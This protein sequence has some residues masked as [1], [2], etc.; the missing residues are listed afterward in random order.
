MPRPRWDRYTHCC[1]L[2]MFCWARILAALVWGPGGGCMWCRHP[3][4]YSH[5]TGGT[6]PRPH[7]YRSPAV[8]TICTLPPPHHW[9]ATGGGG[10]EWR[11]LIT[12]LQ[13]LHLPYL[14]STSTISTIYVYTPAQCRPPLLCTAFYA[15]NILALLN[16]FLECFDDLIPPEIVLELRIEIFSRAEQVSLGSVCWW[17]H[18]VW[19]VVRWPGQNIQYPCQCQHPL[20]K[21][22]QQETGGQPAAASTNI[23][24]H[25][26]CRSI[27]QLQESRGNF[28]KSSVCNDE[29]PLD[30][31]S[32]L[33]STGS[34]SSVWAGT[35]I[36]G[37]RKN[38]S[39]NITRV[40]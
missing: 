14:L 21:N 9:A 7:G 38:C 23:T 2:V 5:Y 4:T 39:S 22:R 35:E 11:S 24:S 12:Y 26:L 36:K 32:C 15:D 13:Y 31:H 25:K 34:L 1:H 8:V 20:N 27:N 40:F 16:F 28:T 30:C 29:R 18:I 10:G 3:D 37:N 19:N 33:L 17:R 6:S